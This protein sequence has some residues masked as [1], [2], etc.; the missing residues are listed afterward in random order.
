MLSLYP[1]E[2]DMPTE[3]IL[4]LQVASGELL[5]RLT[6]EPLPFGLRSGVPVRGFLRDLYLD[7]PDGELQRRGIG[8]RFR[9]TLDDRRFLTVTMR[10]AI[11]PSELVEWQQF[12]SEVAEVDPVDALRGISEPARRL[13]GVIDPR[14]CSVR[15]ELET[16]RYT[17][18][19]RQR[20]I[21]LKLFDIAYDKIAVRSGTLVREFQEIRIKRLKRGAPDLNDVARVLR[22]NPGVKS[23]TAGKLERAEELLNAM[24]GEAPLGDVISAPEVILLATASG[25]VAMKSTGGVLR[26]PVT[27]G[28]GE[29]ACEALLEQSIGNVQSER[30]LLDTLC[31]TKVSPAMEVWLSEGALGDPDHMGRAGCEWVCWEDVFALVGTPALRDPRTLAAIGLLSRSEVAG[32]LAFRTGAPVE[33]VLRPLYARSGSSKRVLWETQGETAGGTP[34]QFLN[35]EISML[36][37]NQRLIEL[38][39][40]PDVPLLARLRF[41]AIFSSNLDEFF[42][43]QV[44][45][46]KSSLAKAAAEPGFDGMGTQELLDAVAIKIRYLSDRLRKCLERSCL[47]ELER[48]GIRV[49]RWSQTS[50]TDREYLEQYYEEQIFPLLTPHAITKAPGHPFPH[51]ANLGLSLALIVRDEDSGR[52]RFGTLALPPGVS[53]FIRLGERMDFVPLEEVI[54]ENVS[55]VYPGRTVEAA[56]CFRVT[57]AGDLDLDEESADDLLEAVEKEVR[58]RPFAG[59]VRLELERKMP[60]ELRDLLQRELR[61]FTS[62]RGGGPGAAGIFEV[63]GMIDLTGF[64]EIA[65]L[66]RSD[67]D[68][69]SFTGLAPIEST[70]DMFEAIRESDILVHHPYDTFEHSTQRFFE[71]AADDPDVESV[72]LTL[73]RAGGDSPVMNALMR[74]ARR[75]KQ[76]TVFV[77][78]KARFDEERNAEWVRRLEAVGVHVVYGFVRLKTHAKIALIVRREGKAVRRYAHIGTGNYNAATAR[79]YTDLGLLSADADLGADLNDLFNE[80]TGASSAPQ[81]E[82]RKLL[83]APTA[84]LDRFESLIQREI[85]HAKAGRPARIRVKVNGLAYARIVEHLYRASQAGVDIGLIVRGVCILRPGVPELSDRIRVV[86]HVGRFL[87]HARIFN[88]ANGGNEEYYIGSADWRP[89]NL[90]RRVE[91]VA[92]VTDERACMRLDQILETELA[93]RR[94]WELCAD[95]SYVRRTATDGSICDSA[96]EQFVAWTDEPKW[97]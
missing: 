41:L 13:R 55:H 87:E 9:I 84:M 1:I 77:E 10:E 63:D 7:T 62:G 78:L 68:Y 23:V 54:K 6:K 97:S 22:E 52:L 46:L 92:P 59:V 57:R 72:R 11:G 58:R 44:G 73:Y 60:R 28:Q 3:T 95:G 24:E 65:A 53:R 36:Q 33:G 86:T 12:E 43:V 80:L 69:P 25:H 30:R 61:M 76:V 79:L 90:R 14:R 96:Q 47:P 85:E 40:D 8:C 21:P 74:A 91:V 50:S 45:S 32:E 51:I 4:R 93:D 27:E 89:R 71:S 39:E 31:G 82:F 5:S 26:L 88:F 70:R 64:M 48:Q 83:V 16:E 19:A 17:R 81:T 38:A 94:A 18:I 29:R 37:F 34:E 35:G 15:I 20:T 56:H 49:L 42:M 75:G 66:G 2:P 67:L